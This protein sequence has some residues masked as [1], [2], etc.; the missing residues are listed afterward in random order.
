[1][2]GNYAKTL[3][4]HSIRFDCVLRHFKWKCWDKIPPN[5]LYSV[6]AAVSIG[7]RARKRDEMLDK[8][9]T[10]PK[11]KQSS[12]IDAPEIIKS[13]AQLFAAQ[14]KSNDVAIECCSASTNCCCWPVEKQDFF[15]TFSKLNGQFENWNI[16]VWS[17]LS[18]SVESSVHHHI[19]WLWPASMSSVNQISQFEL[20]NSFDEF[21]FKD[22][23][24][25]YRTRSNAMQFVKIDQRRT[26][27]INL[28]EID[29]RVYH[30]SN[31]SKSHIYLCILFFFICFV[32][33]FFLFYSIW[34]DSIGC[35]GLINLEVVA[36]ISCQF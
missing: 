12:D 28:I 16:S 32:L 3:S 26:S 10:E 30:V 36:K 34:I 27:M 17:F 7:N 13:S 1:M 15:S 18:V 35:D 14:Q 6:Q 29:R 9:K 33:V 19:D 31:L 23:D 24:T 25:R 8:K 5:G 21:Y 20:L 22:T 2:I 4:I 11:R